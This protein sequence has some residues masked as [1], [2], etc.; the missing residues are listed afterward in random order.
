M[1]SHAK[2]MGHPVH[3]MLIVFPLGLLAMAVIFDLIGLAMGAGGWSQAA[4]SMI[5]AGVLTGLIAA[6]F[7]L[8]DWLGIP[9]RT[10]AKKVGAVHG[11]GNV[12]VLLLFGM[13]WARRGVV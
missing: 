13:S 3:Q 8:V 12:F 9:S 1:E 10:R 7:G 5:A 4:Y 11:I 2:L 6:P